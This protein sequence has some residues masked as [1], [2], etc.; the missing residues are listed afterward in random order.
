MKK[1]F[2]FTLAEVL[3]TLGIIG[4]VAALTMPAL[5]S[6]HRKK[7][8]VTQLKKSVNTVSNG[9]RLILAEH[10]VDKLS[11]TDFLLHVSHAKYDAAVR[12]YIANYFNVVDFKSVYGQ[13]R[14]YKALAS[15]SSSSY[16][17]L[18]NCYLMK[19]ADGS[20]ICISGNSNQYLSAYIDINGF[21]K[22]PNTAGVDFFNVFF[23][24]NGIINVRHGYGYDS[25]NTMQYTCYQA[26]HP[27]APEFC[28]KLIMHDNWE[29]TYY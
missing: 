14:T 5:I 3:I 19:L 18:L 21:E 20:E 1:F 10:N 7:V 24:D 23:D 29:I 8:Y 27:Y 9:V 12:S 11:D 26:G 28:F 17:Y 4:V 16:N 6:N 15:N 22:L 2:A 25:L 13:Y